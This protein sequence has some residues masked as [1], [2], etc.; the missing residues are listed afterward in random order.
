MV[1]L[2]YNKMFYIYDNIYVFFLCKM[3]KYDYL[4]RKTYYQAF[5]N[6]EFL[7]MNL[8]QL[9]Y[10]I[11]AA[12]NLNFSKAAA[13]CFIS[14]TAMTQQIK[15]L[16]NTIGV[17]LFIRDKHHVELTTAG[18]IYLNEAKA[19][20]DRSNEAMRLAR[21]AS[22][23]ISGKISIGY[24]R[25]YGQDGLAENIRGFHLA[26]P[27]I[28]LSFVRDNMSSLLEMVE[29]G[30]LDVAFTVATGNPLFSS[31]NKRFLQSYPIMA[32]LP[33]D[34][35]L[36]GRESLTL[37]E[38][39]HEE[40]I[41]MQPSDRPK[42]QMEESLIIYERGGY[43]PNVVRIEADPETLLLMISVGL[44]ISILPEYIIRLYRKKMDL[45]II[46]LLNADGTAETVDFEISW[47]KSATN[48]AID[49][50]IEFL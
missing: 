2:R 3:I 5:Q 49:R 1:L 12:E 44:G 32:A 14:Q 30:T 34:H 25:G 50:L 7:D 48:P 46:P 21:T 23:G 16:E 35:P 20:I 19:I 29:K 18:R 22:E 10:F 26:Y 37:T 9:E 27:N 17:P 6:E 38:L 8:N 39:K 13:K 11:S 41:M 28:E 36:A 24:I 15:S 43:L 45:S 40:F 47:A 42:D 4:I 33:S 31:R